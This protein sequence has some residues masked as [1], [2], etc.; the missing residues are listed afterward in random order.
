MHLAGWVR[1]MMEDQNRETKWFKVHHRLEIDSVSDVP[2]GKT[3]RRE[4][5]RVENRYHWAYSLSDKIR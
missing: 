1:V 5:G 4:E 3:R 2:E